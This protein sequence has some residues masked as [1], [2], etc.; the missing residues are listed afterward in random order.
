M[1]S[2]IQSFMAGFFC[3]ALLPN[4]PQAFTV[5]SDKYAVVFFSFD[6]RVSQYY[7]I[8]DF[9]RE[10]IMS[11]SNF[12]WGTATSSYQIEGAVS[13]GGRGGS[14][15]DTF[16]QEPGRILD[17]SDGS[18]A[19]DHYHL[20]KEDI[21]LMASLGINSYRFSISWSRIFSLFLSA[22]DE[23]FFRSLTTQRPFSTNS[24]PF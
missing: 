9:Q 1:F 16:C 7:I 18:V 13:E 14:I 23:R 12:I 11:K 15:W 10:Y 5:W 20:F 3:V 6:K 19:C 8:S 24:Q 17:G 21:K 2:A 22:A 4:E